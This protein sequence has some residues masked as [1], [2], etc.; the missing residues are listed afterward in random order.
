MLIFTAGD[1]AGEYFDI[2]I[3]NF[4]DVIKRTRELSEEDQEIIY[5]VWQTREASLATSPNMAITGGNTSN[6]ALTHKA[7][8]ERL[9]H[10][11]EI[12]LINGRII[13]RDDEPLKTW[14]ANFKPIT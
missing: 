6:P 8:T 3:R 2:Y 5:T 11:R 13:N 10:A 1:L 14:N 12:G 9:K 4:L 7:L